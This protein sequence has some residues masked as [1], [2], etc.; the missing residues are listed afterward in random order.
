MR[1]TK[2]QR[3]RA[4]QLS[5]AELRSAIEADVISITRN[6]WFPWPAMATSDDV[7]A[8]VQRR[9]DGMERTRALMAVVAAWN[10]A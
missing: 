3:R 7:Q 2:F 8:E 4:R 5:A 6:D 1:Q 9:L 10:R